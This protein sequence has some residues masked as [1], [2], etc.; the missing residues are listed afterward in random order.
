MFTLENSGPI[1]SFHCSED[2]SQIQVL[3]I[4]IDKPCRDLNNFLQV[5]LDSFEKCNQEQA[6][7]PWLFRKAV[8]GA[9]FKYSRG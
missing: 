8:S 5:A 9:E 1:L 6:Q 3:S 2:Q 4:Q 7:V